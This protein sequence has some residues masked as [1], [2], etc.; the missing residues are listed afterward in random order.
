M[1]DPALIID[2]TLGITQA[3]IDESRNWEGMAL[4]APRLPENVRRAWKNAPVEVLECLVG[5]DPFWRQA[6]Q[7]DPAKRTTAIYRFKSGVTVA[8]PQPEFIEYPVETDQTWHPRPYYFVRLARHSFSLISA[9]G[10]VGF[11]GVTYRRHANNEFVYGAFDPTQGTPVSV[12][13]TSSKNPE[14]KV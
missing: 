3:D 1:N 10:Y 14:R 8:K 4:H 11:V 2:P 12:R 7:D 13:F 5:I 6:V 9:H